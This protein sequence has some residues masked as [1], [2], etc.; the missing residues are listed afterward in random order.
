MFS[1]ASQY[2]DGADIAF[3]ID[4]SG[5]ISRRNY[6]REKAFVKAVMMEL[7]KNSI[8]L[9]AAVVLY[10]TRASVKLDFSQKFNLQRFISTI[11]NLPHERG[12]TRTDTALIITSEYI[13]T[14]HT[15]NQRH[16]APKIAILITD[17][18][19]GPR[20]PDFLPV[21]NASEPLKQKGVRILAVGIGKR[22]DKQELLEITERK[23]DLIISK[24]F[25]HLSDLV[26]DMVANIWMA[27]GKKLLNFY[28]FR[29]FYFENMDYSHVLSTGLRPLNLG[30]VPWKA[31]T[32]SSCPSILPG[33]CDETTVCLQFWTL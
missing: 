17:G 4:S 8:K 11:D 22:I 18:K 3:I 20:K 23:T 30:N 28:C 31:K 16:N 9:N 13:F 33:H 14:N 29:L 12:V 24:H 27:I 32:F 25:S 15:V 19:A 10:S 5:S 1:D 7:V 26:D 2:S 6:L 21:S